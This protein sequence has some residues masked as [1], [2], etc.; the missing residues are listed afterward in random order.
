MPA[1]VVLQIIFGAACV[2]GLLKMIFTCWETVVKLSKFGIHSYSYSLG[3]IFF[4]FAVLVDGQFEA[5]LLTGGP[6]M[7]GILLLL[8]LFCIYG[9]GEIIK[10][11]EHE[12][13]LS[14]GVL[15]QVVTMVKDIHGSNQVSMP[16]RKIDHH[17]SCIG[18]HMPIME[19]YKFN[20]DGS[21]KD[22]TYVTC[23]NVLRDHNGMWMKFFPP[24]I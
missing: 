5:Y 6:M 9:R 24:E 1:S 22:G 14:I 12:V 11:F 13:L 8:L 17:C 2:D 21:L 19:W 16:N 7:I 3:I 18:W 15:Q 23:A 10:V 20:V 4:R